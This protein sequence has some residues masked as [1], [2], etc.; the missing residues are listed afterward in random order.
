LTFK[1]AKFL[2]KPTNK[3]GTQT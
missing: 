2:A 3:S 1:R